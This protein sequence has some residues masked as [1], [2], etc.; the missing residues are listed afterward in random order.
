MIK[1]ISVYRNRKKLKKGRDY[2][3]RQR[4][5]YEAVALKFKPRKNTTIT[6]NYNTKIE[7]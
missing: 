5:D 3:I 1:I 6:V 2:F 7:Y 4:L